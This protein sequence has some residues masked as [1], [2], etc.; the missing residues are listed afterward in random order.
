MYVICVESVPEI[1]FI[2]TTFTSTH[3]ENYKIQE[4]DGKE[5]DDPNNDESE[6]HTTLKENSVTV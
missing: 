1:I 4:L 2:D 3:S 6:N 5:D